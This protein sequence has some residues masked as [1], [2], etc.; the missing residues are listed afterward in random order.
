MIIYFARGDQT[1][2]IDMKSFLFIFGAVLGF[3]VVK[4][5]Q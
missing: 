1:Q 5:L 4:V 3:T 2:I